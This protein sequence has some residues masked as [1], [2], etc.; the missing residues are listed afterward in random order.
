M[1]DKS[2]NP[3]TVFDLFGDAVVRRVL[4]AASDAPVSANELVDDLDVSPPTVYRRINELLDHEFLAER[5]RIDGDGNQYRVFETTLRRV[6]FRV[7][8]GGYDVDIGM[9]RDLTDRFES[10][11]ADLERARPNGAGSTTDRIERSDADDETHPS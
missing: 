5:R 7:E 2:W 1:G 11:W 8:D 6:E 3:P 4:V 10:F 9:R